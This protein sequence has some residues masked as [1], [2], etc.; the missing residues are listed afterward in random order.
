MAL[1]DLER[2]K[3]T[4]ILVC[5]VNYRKRDT[6]DRD[7]QIVRDY[8]E[9]Y[10]LECR[11]LCPKYPGGN[12]QAWARQVRYDFFEQ[13]A[14]ECGAREI[15]VA[16]QQD[17]LVE[18]WVFQRDRG[19]VCDWYGLRARTERHG[20]R[21]V[22]PLLRYSKQDLADYCHKQGVPFGIDE[23]NLTDAY[24]R[25]RI[26]HRLQPE[27]KPRLLQQ[28]SQANRQRLAQKRRIRAF[29]TS[30]KAFDLLQE[31]DAWLLLEAWLHDQ[32]G[33]HFG[34]KECEDLTRQLQGDCL[35]DLDSWWLERHQNSLRLQRKEEQKMLI[36]EIPTLEDLKRLPQIREEGTTMERFAVTES[37]FP[38]RIRRPVQGDYIQLR[39]GKKKLARFF[40]D[41]K[42]G[43]IDRMR[44]EVL[45]NSQ[46]KLI[47]VPE[48]GCEKDHFENGTVLYWH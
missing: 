5:H 34:R 48:I 7:E 44:W 30:H 25:N 8:C 18:T 46:G 45:E 23:S 43:R 28:I 35:I 40:I 42:I 37:D 31:E 10:S 9:R 14:R 39:M 36:M 24:A 3:G 1:L 32:T 2:R 20:L 16:H 13:T 19:M 29:F 6:A 15:L 47:Y 11:V 22:R 21:I 12:F 33:K 38:M 26:R 27:E 17:D 4:R 41:R